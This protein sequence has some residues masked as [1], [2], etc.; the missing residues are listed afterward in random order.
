MP[1]SSLEHQDDNIYYNSTIVNNE[2]RD[3]AAIFHETR[4]TS[5]LDDPAQYYLTIAR[6]TLPVT[7]LPI[8]NFLDNTYAVTLSFSG[9]DFMEFVTYTSLTINPFGKQ[10]V[11]NYQHFI[12][13]INT[14][15]SDAFTALKTAFPGAPPVTAPRME[16]NGYTNGVSIEF[17]NAYNPNVASPTIEVYVNDFLYRFF[18]NIENQFF[19]YIQPADKNYQILIKDNGNN[20]SGGITT[21]SQEYP[22]F[23]LWYDFRNI[24]VTSNTLP[25][26]SEA[27]ASRDQDGTNRSLSIVTDFIPFQFGIGEQTKTP[28]V[29]QPQPQ[30]RLIDLYSHQPIRSIDYQVFWEDKFGNI[31]EFLLN[32]GQEMTMKMLFVKKDIQNKY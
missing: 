20:V 15:F 27:I 5:L 19:G 29:Y 10:Y 25:I 32:P 6:F 17:E 13:M 31:N 4:Q 12:D 9:S 24:L 14:A 22:T 3:T 2:L 23:Y 26:S 18:P 16:Y 28:F 21:M 1:F 7:S 8:F 30:Y 11:F